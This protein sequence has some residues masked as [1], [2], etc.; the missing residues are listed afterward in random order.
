MSQRKARA[1]RVGKAAFQILALGEGDAVHDAMQ[2]AEFFFQLLRQLVD[3]F[4]HRYV[5]RQDQRTGKSL[6]QLAHPS[7]HTFAFIC[8][9]KAGSLFGQALGNR[10]G[11]APVVGH[12]HDDDVFSV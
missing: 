10:P 9:G 5:A 3:V 11:N 7:F 12:S 1:G 6:S 4:I 8:K 2:D